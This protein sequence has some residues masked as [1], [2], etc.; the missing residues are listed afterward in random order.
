MNKLN[1]NQFSF[2]SYKIKK[3]QK[4]IFNYQ[5][6]KG[7]QSYYFQEKI[8]FPQPIPKTI[9][10]NLLDVVLKNLSLILGV[11]Y[12]KTF[13]PKQIILTNYQLTKKQAN[14]WNTVYT[15]GLG[16]FFYK[17]RLDFRSLV[18]FPYSKIKKRPFKQ[19]KINNKKSILGFGGGKDSVVAVELLKKQKKDFSLFVLYHQKKPLIIKEVAKII[20]KPVIWIKRIIDPQ[21]F[22]LNKKR[23]VYNGHVPFNAI[24]SFVALLIAIIYD[25]SEIITANEKDA[26]EG[27]LIYL[28]EEINH[29]WSKSQDYEEL[30]NQYVKENLSLNINYYSVLRS[31]DELQIAQEFSR[32]PQYF[33]YFSSCNNNF[34]I[35]NKKMTKRWCGQCPKCLFTFLVLAPF[36]KKETMVKIFSQNLLQKKEL[37]RL[38]EQLL[39][40]KANKPFEC[41]GTKETV[42][43]ASNKLAQMSV[44]QNDFLI[45]F[46]KEKYAF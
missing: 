1:S 8:I 38:Y 2:L 21:L 16:E 13:C 45:K 14:F 18:S 40:L 5:L 7:N 12:W 23:G 27:N 39:G 43:K 34:K 44:Y 15:K 29:Q 10:K 41:V 17:N 46:F 31:F 3:N 6:T 9:N 42:I 4:I 36:I 28:N 26:N 22:Q 32:H 25:F 24:L 19:I 11:S 20:N 35:I 37:L 33:F 30:F